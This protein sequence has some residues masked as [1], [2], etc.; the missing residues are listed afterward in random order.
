MGG[1]KKAT[2]GVGRLTDSKNYPVTSGNRFDA[3]GKGRGLDGQDR[4]IPKQYGKGIRDGAGTDTVH[5]ISDTL[6][7]D[8][9]GG[10]KKKKKKVKGIRDGAGKT[11]VHSI[12]S[13]LRQD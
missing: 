13:T 8:R 6:R 4:A 9:S 1:K 12:S 7:P 2:G 5:S 10:Q 11:T 3:D